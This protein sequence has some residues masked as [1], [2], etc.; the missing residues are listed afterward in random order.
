MF[1]LV[2]STSNLERISS[3][4]LAK[5][6]ELLTF[7]SSLRKQECSYSEQMTAVSMNSASTKYATVCLEDDII[8]CCNMGQ[9][10]PSKLPVA[11]LTNTFIGPEG[12]YHA[13]KN[14]SSDRI[15]SQLNPVLILKY[16]FLKTHF[17]IIL[18]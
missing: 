13:H 3:L 6:T 12:H 17:S 4:L 2:S 18:A 11:D 10:L 16:V 14:L 7:M 1:C 5:A 15:S 9:R 8:I